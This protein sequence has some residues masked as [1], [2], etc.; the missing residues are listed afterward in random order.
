[1]DLEGLKLA[2]KGLRYLVVFI[3]K[4]LAGILYFLV[5]LLGAVTDSGKHS[6]SDDW[7]DEAPTLKQLAYLVSL[8]APIHEGMT[9]QEA[10]D[11]LDDY[12]DERG[13]PEGKK[14]YHELLSA[15]EER[16]RD[17]ESVEDIMEDYY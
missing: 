11:I 9:R 6:S 12:A 1:M 17:G 8:D 14:L 5:A 13:D 3:W 4:V 15:F 16:A 7:G 10:S 2:A